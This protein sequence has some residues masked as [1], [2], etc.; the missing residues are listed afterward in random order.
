MSG[1]HGNSGL[2]RRCLC[3]HAIMDEQQ[4]ENNAHRAF[5]KNLYEAG[6]GPV[7]GRNDFDSEWCEGKL[8]ILEEGVTIDYD[9]GSNSNLGFEQMHEYWG[10]W[11]SKPDKAKAGEATAAKCGV[12]DD[13]D[14]DHDD[15]GGGDGDGGGGGGDGDGGGGGKIAAGK[16]TMTLDDYAENITEDGAGA[17][18]NELEP[19]PEPANPKAAEPPEAAFRHLIREHADAVDLEVDGVAYRSL[20][21]TV[22]DGGDVHPLYLAV[23]GADGVVERPY[24]S[25]LALSPDLIFAGVPRGARGVFMRLCLSASVPHRHPTVCWVHTGWWRWH[26][27]ARHAEVEGGQ[28]RSSARAAGRARE[29]K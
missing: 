8:T 15:D 25:E 9:D 23:Q 20:G 19:E 10:N 26:D 16:R 2:K 3:W 27:G 6:S 12:D 1:R 13:D 17:G 28:G 21:D 11:Y 29:Y 22:K 7:Q 24:L 4:N 14:D 5:V 18:T